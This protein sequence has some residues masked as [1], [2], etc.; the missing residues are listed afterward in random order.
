MRKYNRILL[1]NNEKL[2]NAFHSCCDE[3][4][5]VIKSQRSSDGFIVDITGPGANPGIFYLKSDI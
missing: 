3:K 1:S 5:N 2:D 4:L